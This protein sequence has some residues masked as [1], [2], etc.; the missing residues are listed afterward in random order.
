MIKEA[1]LKK[2][3]QLARLKLSDEELSVYP[4][5]FA[6]IL[7]YFETISKVD[8]KDVEPLVTPTDM[9]QFLREDEI[10]AWPDADKAMA[11]APEVSGNLFKVPPVV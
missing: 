8:T 10:K 9:A 1:D 2:V 5:Q 3:A 11:N 6:A 7:E 4:Q